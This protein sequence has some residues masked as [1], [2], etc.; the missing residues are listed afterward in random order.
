MCA[1][2]QICTILR[3]T[4]LQASCHYLQRQYLIRDR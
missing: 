4:E 2:L 1:I 3:G